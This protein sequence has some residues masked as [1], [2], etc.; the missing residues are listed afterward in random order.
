MKKSKIRKPF[1]KTY[2]HFLRYLDTLTIKRRNILLSKIAS[3]NEINTIIELFYNF[4]NYNIQCD[5]KTLNS[6]KKHSKYIKNIIKKSIPISKKRLLLISHKGRI[7]LSKI[8]KL[9]LPI[10]KNIFI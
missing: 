3:D 4:L 9:A 7:T 10:L 6:L 1:C 8:L 2:I 5:K